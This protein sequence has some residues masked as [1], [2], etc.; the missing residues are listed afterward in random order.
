MHVALATGFAQDCS[1]EL[2]LCCL[3]NGYINKTVRPVLCQLRSKLVIKVMNI[4]KLCSIT[5][6]MNEIVQDGWSSKWRE[7]FNN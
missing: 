6:E 7:E 2:N 3:G 1:Y 4:D 5:Q